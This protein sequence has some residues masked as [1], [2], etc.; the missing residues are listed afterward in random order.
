MSS[1][2]KSTA[3]LNPK[4]THY[5]F[6]GPPGAFFISI[7]VPVTTYA[8][9]FG[10][11]HEAGGCP[12][13][14]AGIPDRVKFS[15]QDPNFWSSLWDTEATVMYL[16]WYIFC[17]VAWAIL[18][19]DQ[20]EGGVMRNGLKKSYKINAFTTF[21]LAMG[22]TT[23]YIYKNGPQSFTFLYDKFVPFVTASVIM[24][25]AQGVYVYAASFQQGKLL[26]LGGNSGN[27]IYDVRRTTF[28]FRSCRVP[29]P[30]SL[31]RATIIPIFFNSSVT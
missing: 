1:T 28:C 13:P 4:T 9:F 20:V 3:D 22:V 2:T 15:L 17:V 14:L 8:L 23:G 12:P 26:A 7:A 10:C 31:C 27:F 11:S 5:E 24:S 29:R 16:A 25:V 6:L 18:P 19:G 30:A 21:L